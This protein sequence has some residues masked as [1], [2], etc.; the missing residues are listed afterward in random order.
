MNAKAVPVIPFPKPQQTEQ[1]ARKS[2]YSDKFEQG[3]VMSSRLYRKEVYPFIS[4][5]ARN[6]YAELENRINGYSKESDFVSY[7]Q[8]QG[9]DLPGARQMGRKTVTNGLKEL[10]KLEVISIVATGK[11]G[12]KKY[13]INEISIKD[14][15]TNE[16]SSLTKLV[17]KGNQDRFTNETK[18]SSLSEPTIDTSLESLD[19]KKNNAL[20]DNLKTEMFSDSVEYHQDDKKQYSLIEISKVYSIQSDLT[21]QA[22]RQAPDLDDSKIL[23]ELKNFAQ[24]STGREK[25]TAQGWMNYWTYR[26][27]KLTAP[28]PKKQKPTNPKSKGLSEAQIKMFASVLCNYDPFASLYSNI[29]ETQKAFEARVSANLGKLE[30]IKTYAPYLTELGYH[31]QLE[32]FNAE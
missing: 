18:T 31:V 32:E 27:Q 10:L 22:K 16:T 28:K 12:V 24:W 19:I 30:H 6:V 7:S 5:A 4:D 29:G 13:L 9:G 21:A 15:F 23:S 26:I 2:M 1:E 17:H 11:Q 20:V 14:R 3:Y 8:L 25:T